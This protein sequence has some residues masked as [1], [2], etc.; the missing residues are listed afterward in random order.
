MDKELVILVPTEAAAYEVVR[1]LKGL[2]DQGS[3]ELYSST[4]VMK[5]A[6]GSLTVKE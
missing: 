4:V 1:S 2:D 5:T 3:I 6:S